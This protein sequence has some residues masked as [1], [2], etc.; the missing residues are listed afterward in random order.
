MSA[1][2]PQSLL[3]EMLR[4]FTTLARH[5][6]LSRAVAEL[7]STRQTV[8]RH[9]SQLETLKGGALFKLHDRQYRLTELG[10]RVLPEAQDLVARA[11]GWAQ[12]NSSIV[13]G[14]QRL[15]QVGD[16]GFYLYQQQHPIGRIFR[17]ENPFLRNVLQ[18]WAV[19]GGEI[20]HEAMQAVREN[21]MV[22][23]RSGDEWLCVEIGEKSSFM[24]WFGR[25]IAQSSI[26]RAMDNFPAQDSF[27]Y[28]LRLA[29]QEVETT[30]GVRLDHTLTRIARHE[31][32]ELIPLSFQRLLAAAKFPDG[33]F[34]M[35][36]TL[37]RTYDIEI[38]GVDDSIRCDMPEELLM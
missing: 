37:L 13:N 14:L 7:S 19:S 22:F 35:I 20:E 38:D 28:L 32:G 17:M 16:D 34:A 26:G 1:P 6:N 15:A 18:A 29:Y 33:S 9:I 30:E 8:R 2:F 3:F 24:S 12:G 36:S 4:S 31:G 5:L 21:V 11:E 10:E 23:R 25:S 27:R